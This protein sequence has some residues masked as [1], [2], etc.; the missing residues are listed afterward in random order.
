M[1]QH[2]TV[3]FAVAAISGVVMG[4]RPSDGRAEDTTAPSAPDFDGVYEATDGKTD[5][6]IAAMRFRGGTAY[7][8]VPAGC[9]TKSCVDVGTYSLD[10]LR[11]VLTLHSTVTGATRTLP[12]RVLHVT[13]PAATSEQLVPK[14]EYDLLPG[15][16]GDVLQPG[17]SDRQELIRR[18]DRMIAIVDAIVADQKIRAAANGADIARWGP[19]MGD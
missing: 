12:V 11:T 8:L 16:A 15:V 19:I 5:D 3:I 7:S 4:C 10:A 17:T 1:I 14:D 6:S 2:Q 13:S 18:S 9:S